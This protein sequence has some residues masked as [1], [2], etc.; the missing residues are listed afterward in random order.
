MPESAIASAAGREAEMAEPVRL[1]GGLGVHEVGRLEVVD[2]CG[3]L[4]A[5]AGRIEPID[6][7]DRRLAGVQTG[8][9]ALEADADRRD[10][11]RGR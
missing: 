10:E 3:H 1:A 5:E 8:P 4:R 9:K 2:L 7:L 11:A 6:A